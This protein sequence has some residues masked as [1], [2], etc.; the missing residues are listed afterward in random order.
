VTQ[1]SSTDE[2]HQQRYRSEMAFRR[3]LLR[4][5]MFVAAGIAA[6]LCIGLLLPRDTI[7]ARSEYRYRTIVVRR[8]ASAPFWAWPLSWL[9]DN[10]QHRFEYYRGEASL[11]SCQSYVG[12]S[13]D[14][15]YKPAQK[16]L[17]DVERVIE[18]DRNV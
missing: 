4:F 8:V 9:D 12:E 15:K 16:E 6:Y 14:P 3:R 2:L 17:S 5:V 7:L 10:P 18:L 13:F 11:W 1:Q